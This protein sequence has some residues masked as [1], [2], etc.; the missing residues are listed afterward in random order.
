MKNQDEIIKRRVATALRQAGG[1]YT[2]RI[3]QEAPECVDVFHSDKPK[4]TIVVVK[5]RKEDKVDTAY[6]AYVFLGREIHSASKEY[7]F[8]TGYDKSIAINLIDVLK[9]Q[10][11]E[12]RNRPHTLTTGDIMVYVRHYTMRKVYFYEVTA[13]HDEWHVILQEIEWDVISGD[14]QNGAIAPKKGFPK[15]GA[16]PIKVRISNK[17]G[18][19]TASSKKRKFNQTLFKFYQW[20]GKPEI[21]SSD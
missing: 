5:N 4:G 11:I 21:V 14:W 20:D 1:D 18:R 10:E 17:D 13:I 2:F 16:V 7:E 12:D 8:K 19:N 3:R 6:K 15:K 9:K